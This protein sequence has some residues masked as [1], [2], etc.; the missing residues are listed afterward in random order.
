[1]CGA[2]C[3]VD[4]DCLVSDC[5][6]LD[7]CYEG[8]YRDYDDVNNSCENCG[9]TQNSCTI[10]LEFTEEICNNGID[11][12][13]DG[14]PDDGCDCQ[15]GDFDCSGIVTIADLLLLLFDYAGTGP[16]LNDDGYT[17]LSDLILFGRLF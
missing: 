4:D 15:P 2:N 5:Q 6:S 11:E 9:C 3:L 12:D 13:C 14:T 17:D 8:V 7:G 16:D 10:Y 1:M